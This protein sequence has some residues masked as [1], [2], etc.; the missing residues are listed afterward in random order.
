MDGEAEVGKALS[1]GRDNAAQDVIVRR[2]RLGQISNGIIPET[3]IPNLNK[4]HMALSASSPS[5]SLMQF[6][7]SLIVT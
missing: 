6:L 4:A 1:A 7:R 3:S 5:V 2:M